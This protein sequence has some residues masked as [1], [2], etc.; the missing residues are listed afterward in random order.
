MF[1]M[2]S[3]FI[4]VT[5][6][7]RSK[8]WYDD[9]LGLIKVDEWESGTDH[10]VGFVFPRGNTGIAL[11]EVT[12]PQSTVFT[13]KGNQPNVYFNFLSDDI[14]KDYQTLQDNHVTTTPIRHSE[15][16]STFDFED[17]DGNLFSVVQEASHSPYHERHIK[18]LQTQHAE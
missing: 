14:E 1:Q 2:H 7:E 4:P 12:E 5:N 17:P 16:V 8:K 6:I 9:H 13:R 11:I 10:G 15:E 18:D 3:A